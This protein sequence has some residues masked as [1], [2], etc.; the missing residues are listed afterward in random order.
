MV[1]GV[2]VWQIKGMLPTV[3]LVFMVMFVMN[4]MLGNQNQK[5]K[6]RTCTAMRSGH[7]WRGCATHIDK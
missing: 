5:P 6:V 7:C 4:K 2:V 3:V 1:S